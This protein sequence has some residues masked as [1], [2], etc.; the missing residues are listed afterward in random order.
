MSAGYPER[1]RE[2]IDYQTYKLDFPSVKRFPFRGPKPQNLNKKEYFS[3][4]GSAHT[5]GCFSEKPYPTLLQEKLGLPALNLGQG[6]TGPSFF[7]RRKELLDY[8]N[9]GQFLVL[10]VLT[11]RGESNSLLESNQ[12]KHLM[13]R[14]S[15]GIKQPAAKFFEELLKKGEIEQVKRL[16]TENRHSWI[17][18]YRELMKEIRVPIILF[19]FSQRS[20]EDYQIGYEN[21]KSLWGEY[22]QLIDTNTVE[23]ITNYANEWVKCVSTTGMP[24]LLISRFTGEPV[25]KAVGQ[26]IGNTTITVKG[27]VYNKFYPSPEMHIDA[28]EILEPV[29]R[30]YILQREMARI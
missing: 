14:R 27:K 28:A 8:V 24:Q 7:L 30:K 9:N 29:C 12:G 18:N 21:V 5:Y 19:W 25:S 10:Q 15:D 4:I 2:I 22:P 23:Q 16:V 20:P 26:F 11:G 6:G 13:T 3:C 17:K 1:D